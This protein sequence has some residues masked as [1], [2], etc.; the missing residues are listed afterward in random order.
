MKKFYLLLFFVFFFFSVFSQ[1]HI[2]LSFAGKDSVSQ[3]LISLDSVYVKNLTENSDTLLFGP[4]PELSLTATWP[5]GIDE[6]NVNSSGSFMLKQN[7]PNPFQGSTNFSIYRGYRG[8]LNLILFDDIGT[9]LAEYSNVF[10]KGLHSFVIS[11]SV[12]KVMI[13]TVFDANNSKSIKI[14]S[15]GQSNECNTIKYLGQTANAVKNN[16]KNLDNADFIFYLGNL[17]MFT[18]YAKGYKVKSI[19]DNPKADST[20]ILYMSNS[21]TCGTSITV[22]HVILGGVAPVNKT[23]TY[24]TVTNIPGELTKCWIT[25]NLGANHQAATVDDVTEPSAGWYWQFN[26]KQGYKNNGT[27]VTP[28]WTITDISE[29]LDWQSSNDP[30]LLELGSGWRLPTNSEWHNVNTIGG[31]ID[32]NGP[33]DS[34]LKLHAAG[35]LSHS[36][37]SLNDRG[38]SGYYWS[39]SQSDV[40]NSWYLYFYSGSSGTPSFNKAL[41]FPIRCLRD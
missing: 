34:A 6:N 13:L 32:W 15:N 18:A 3:N 21:L 9:K 20:Y 11:S 36:D 1:T 28:S 38:M 31:W 25:S 10:E 5:F 35:N 12:N 8:P 40:S 37:G 29:N 26:H 33:W 2:T 41:G 17:T 16:L 7:Y 24:G 30:C 27:T 14:I 39:G 19:L 4:V 23:V 22:N